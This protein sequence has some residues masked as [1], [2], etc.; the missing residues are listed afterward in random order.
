MKEYLLERVTAVEWVA[1]YRLCATFSDG[2]AAEID[3]APL[4]DEGPIFAPW[5][6]RQFF[7]SVR[8]DHGVPVW[9]DDVD[10]SPGSLRA[11]CEAGRV[12]SRHET[13]EW[14]A[15]HRSAPEKV[16]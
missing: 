14:V 12:L 3:L 15:A 7:A 4:L 11:W 9:S 5:R 13:D 2:Y 1:G 16:A 6:D 8:V 10:L